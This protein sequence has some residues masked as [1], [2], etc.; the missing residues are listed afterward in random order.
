MSFIEQA[1]KRAKA[2][3]PPGPATSA[4]IS[5]AA[6][7]AAPPASG[8]RPDHPDGAADKSID[9]TDTHEVLHE[10]ALDPD[11]MRRAG[12]LPPQE[13]EREISEQFRHIKRPLLARAFGR[14]MAP[15]PGG[16]I[17]MI[18]SALAGEGKT[19]CTINLARSLCL[20]T[21]SSV[22]L[23][24]GDTARPQLTRAMGLFGEPGLVD[25]LSDDS[26]DV[27][28][29]VATTSIPKLSVLGAGRISASAPE[30]LGSARMEELLQ[31]LTSHRWPNRIVVLDSPP[32]LMTNEAKTLVDYA[33]QVVLVVRA[34][35]TPHSAVL[36]AISHL[37]EDQ[38]VGLILNESD[39]VAGVGYGYGYGYYGHMYKYGQSTS[40]GKGADDDHQG[41]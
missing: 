15:M 35:T 12:Y 11:A 27:A 37:R 18:S 33:G 38:F 24:D 4:T 30:L 22:L 26:L 5:A 41:A 8:E 9:A 16:R 28:S 40:V 32:L 14:G 1:L 6:A 7:P 39:T 21:D 3:G 29:L 20:E 13:Q 36:D 25:A 2:S 17:V 31:R 23:V 19:F 10:I 34:G